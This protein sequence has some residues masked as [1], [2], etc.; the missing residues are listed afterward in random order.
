MNQLRVVASIA[1]KGT[2]RYTPA[3]IPVASAVLMHSSQQME[4]N[5]NRLVEFEIS[6]I[7]AGEISKRFM[8]IELGVVMVFTGFLSR[9]NRNSKSL[10]FHIVGFEATT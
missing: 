3:G 2:L 4:A 8:D 10:V 9:K 1:E 5:I 6:A 7:A